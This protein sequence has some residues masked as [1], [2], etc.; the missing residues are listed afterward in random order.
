MGLQ[1]QSSNESESIG[2]L[3]LL[4]KAWTMAAS[5]SPYAYHPEQEKKGARY[6]ALVAIVIMTF[7]LRGTPEGYGVAAA[8][9]VSLGFALDILSRWLKEQ[10]A[11]NILISGYITIAV[12]MAVVIII[13]IVAADNRLYSW[14]Q[15]TLSKLLLVVVFCHQLYSL[16]SRRACY[17]WRR[18][19]F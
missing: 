14:S 10:L 11:E 16:L 13:Q 8:T 3:Q 5:A 19:N 15:E 12:L 2:K 9:A 17:G 1:L 7:V 6:L 18:L 4:W